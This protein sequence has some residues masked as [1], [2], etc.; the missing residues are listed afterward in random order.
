MQEAEIAALTLQRG[1]DEVRLVKKGTDWESAEPLTTAGRPGSRDPCLDPG[2]PE[3]ERDLGGEKTPSP[4]AWT[5][6]R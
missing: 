5:G 6:R 1:K 3:E 4:L 2:P